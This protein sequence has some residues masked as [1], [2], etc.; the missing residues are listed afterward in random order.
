M[1]DSLYE[2]LGWPVPMGSNIVKYPYRSDIDVAVKRNE[3]V[4]AKMR[5]FKLT[6]ITNVRTSGD[7]GLPWL[8]AQSLKFV[9]KFE[10]DARSLKF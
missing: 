2:N 5:P 8:S 7:Y 3:N 10:I 4:R 9:E 1:H 6:E